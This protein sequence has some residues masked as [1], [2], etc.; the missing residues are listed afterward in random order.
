MLFDTYAICINLPGTFDRQLR[1]NENQIEGL[2]G[3][4]DGAGGELIGMT[5]LEFKDLGV[6]LRH[7]R[8]LKRMRLKD[9]AA[10][11]GCSQSLLSKIEC[12]RVTPS[13]R[14]LHRIVTVLDTSIASLFGDPAGANVTLY[15]SGE[16]PVVVIDSAASSNSIQLER[17]TPYVEGQSLE[18]NVHVVSPGATNGGEINHVGEEV[19]YVLEGEF[20]LT[21]G[22]TTYHLKA[23]DSFFFRSELP[24]SYR[25][26]G[27]VS[28]RV[29]WVNS[30]PTF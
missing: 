25:N 13:L 18:G 28:A 19:G 16:R 22:S 30:P 21:V 27:A 23:G 8:K 15:R 7:A 5:G 29:L 6:K 14:T 20:E 2:S 10:E 11:V 26:P 4:A 1:N 9:V 3:M 12:N 24:H 17:I